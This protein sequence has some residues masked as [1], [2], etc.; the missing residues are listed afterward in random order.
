M[1]EAPALKVHLKGSFVVLVLLLLLV[2][3][4]CRKQA[5]GD[6]IRLQSKWRSVCGSV[7][8]QNGRDLLAEEQKLAMSEV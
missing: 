4:G 1:T 8:G 7:D 2:I 6:I 5:N 3:F